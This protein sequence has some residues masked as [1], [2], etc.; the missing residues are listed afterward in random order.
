[1]REAL[2]LVQSLGLEISEELDAYQNKY[3]RYGGWG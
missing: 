3:A 1:V 2:E